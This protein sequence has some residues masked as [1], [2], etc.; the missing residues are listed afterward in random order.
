LLYFIYLVSLNALR[1]AIESG[2]L[3]IE[4]TLLPV[5]LLFL[6]LALV[7]LNAQKLGLLLRNTAPPF[8]GGDR[9]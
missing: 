2:K 3:P 9:Q 4:L 7:L 5:H 6:L 8:V 1:G